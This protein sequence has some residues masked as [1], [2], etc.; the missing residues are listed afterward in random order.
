MHEQSYAA[1]GLNPDYKPPI[2]R[3]HMVE[4]IAPEG[5]TFGVCMDSMGQLGIAVKPPGEVWP[6]GLTVSGVNTIEPGNK[7]YQVIND[8]R[9]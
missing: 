6:T 9:D 4:I 8:G 2:P 1:D 5:Y 3:W 7:C